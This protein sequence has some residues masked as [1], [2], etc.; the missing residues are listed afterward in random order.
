M[1]VKGVGRSFHRRSFRS[2]ANIS[3]F[4]FMGLKRASVSSFCAGGKQ[5]PGNVSPG[6]ASRFNRIEP[7]EVVSHDFSELL[8]AS[9]WKTEILRD[10]LRP[11][12]NFHVC[13][14]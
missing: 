5:Q 12:L 11:S 3:G 4:E 6:H 7:G 13:W 8:L 14:H 9:S 2:E 10:Y 1:A